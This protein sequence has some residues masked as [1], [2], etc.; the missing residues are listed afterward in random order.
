MKPEIY[1]EQDGNVA[2]LVLNRPAKLNTMTPDMFV[3]LRELSQQIAQTPSIHVVILRGE[4]ERAFCAGTDVNTLKE[5]E[6]FWAWRNR[7][8]YVTQ[9]RAIRQPVIAVLRGWALGGGHELAVAAD[10]RIAARST[11]I[12]SPEVALGWVGA[13]GTS[14]FLPR[15][16]GYGQTMRLLLT[17][18]RV[19][20]EEA[21]RIGL[22]EEVVDD[23]QELTRARELARQ[24]ASYSPVATQATK[25]AVRAGMGNLDHGLQIE[26]ELMALCFAAG[27]DK[28]GAKLFRERKSS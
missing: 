8:D 19:A 18:Q 21:L 6:D 11:V 20:A 10:I 5:Y 2:E 26:N 22:V 13:G 1:L 25:A 27:N 17:G 15:L 4:G 3:L 28:A 14:Q 9:I 16:I 7:I 23:G 24:I 12:G